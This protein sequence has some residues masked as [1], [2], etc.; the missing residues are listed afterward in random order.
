MQQ[1][2]QRRILQ[3]EEIRGKS[4]LR[5]PSA[6]DLNLGV[7]PRSPPALLLLPEFRLPK[8]N[9]VGSKIDQINA[10]KGDLKLEW[11]SSAAWRMRKG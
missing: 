9:W 7:P 4:G 11:S 10:N 6:A 8:R 3:P 2:M 1:R 5:Q